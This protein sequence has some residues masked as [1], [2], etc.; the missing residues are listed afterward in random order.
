MSWDR[1]GDN[2]PEWPEWEHTSDAAP[3]AYHHLVAALSRGQH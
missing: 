2:F 3:F 1:F